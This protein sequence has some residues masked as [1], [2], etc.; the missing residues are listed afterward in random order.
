MTGSTVAGRHGFERGCQSLNLS[1]L[2]VQQILKVLLPCVNFRLL[3]HLSFRALAALDRKDWPQKTR[4]DTKMNS[5]FLCV[6]V[7][8]VARPTIPPLA[9]AGLVPVER[10]I[11]QCRTEFIP[12][13]R[14]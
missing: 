6:F 14:R 9:A 3:A 2:S 7:L 10:K 12:F 4:K 11:H 5:R 1:V 13:I 8:F